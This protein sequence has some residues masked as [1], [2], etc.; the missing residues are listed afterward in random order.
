MLWI[1]IPL[2]CKH[3]KSF[4]SFKS[5]KPWGHGFGLQSGGIGARLLHDVDFQPRCLG[6]VV[7]F[8]VV[9]CTPPSEGLEHRWPPLGL[10]YMASNLY[11]RER[12]VVKIIDA[13]ERNMGLKEFLYRVKRE[14]PDIVAMSCTAHAFPSAVEALKETSVACPN[15]KTVMGGYHPT[16]TAEEILRAYGFIDYVIRG[17]GERAFLD[18]VD[19]I[20]NGE[21]PKK[22]L[23][24][25]YLKN[26]RVVTNPADMIIDLDALPS[27]NRDLVQGYDYGTWFKGIR[28]TF[29]KF[30]TILTSRGCPYGCRYCCC[31]T[32]SMGRWRTRSVDNVLDELED[33]YG[34]GYGSCVIV[35]DSF[36]LNPKRVLKICEGIKRR[37]IRLQLLCESR[38]DHASPGVLKA[39]KD[40]GFTVVYFG[41]ESGVQRIL[42][43]YGKR[44]T[45]QQNRRAVEEAKKAHLLVIG[46]FIIGA[47][48]E[49]RREILQTLKFASSLNLHGIEINVLDLTPGMDLWEEAKREGRIGE[50]DWE[51]HR[52]VYECYGNFT[53]DEL[54][55]LRRYGY[56]LFF[57]NWAKLGSL[58]ELM[59]ELAVNPYAR[60]VVSSNLLNGNFWRFLRSSDL[61]PRQ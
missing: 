17:E 44:I 60:R 49:T 21:E 45:P 29:E 8:K 13:F 27:P 30:T 5:S 61:S 41:M 26:G 59:S 33:I 52:K 3:I 37:K 42:D 20:A 51:R 12:H 15:A 48:V 40:A 58:K 16:F 34:R 25:C 28:L 36:M 4:S 23:G 11:A 1:S 19:H 9:F 43:Y 10:L 46:S 24:V 18:L 55:G 31:T 56:R 54:E 35:D 57:E 53:G 47:P 38:A 6:S 50:K 7:A 39:M 32:F 14:D 2:S 22:V